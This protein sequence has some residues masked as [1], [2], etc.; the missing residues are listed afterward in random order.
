MLTD[1]CLF[2][3]LQ[4]MS[5]Q[6]HA[7]G[8]ARRSRAECNS[9]RRRSAELGVEARLRSQ[10]EQLGGLRSAAGR[11]AACSKVGRSMMEALMA[12]AR[13]TI[14]RSVVGR[15]VVERWGV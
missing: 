8:G 11:S 12:A 14:E 4:G 3:G 15:S 7:Q 13:S 10:I 6:R 5:I 9:D 2:G 1:A